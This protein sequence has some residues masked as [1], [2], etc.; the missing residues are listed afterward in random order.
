MLKN[1]I[2][3]LLGVFLIVF[4]V[5]TGCGQSSSSSLASEQIIPFDSDRWEI[6]AE[7]SK[8]EEYL[9]QQSLLL[10]GGFA[11]VE[12][13]NFTD[14]IIEYDIA[15]EKKL[16]FLG[17]V[18]RLQDKENYEH[19]YIRP[20]Q[21]GNP[22]ANQYTPEYNDIPGWQL[23]SGEGYG[24]AVEYDFEGWNHVKLIVSG[25][26]AEV[27]IRDMNEPAL[28][29]KELKREVEAGKVGFRVA[30]FA[31]A[32]LANFSYEN[33]SN[34][35]L[36]GSKEPEVTPEGTISLWSVSNSFP[37]ENLENQYLLAED[38]EEKFQWNELGIKGNG[39]ANLAEVQGIEEGNTAF[40]KVTINSDSDV[41]KKLK[42]GF[43]DRVKVYFNDRLLYGGIDDARSRDYRFLGTIGLFDELYLPLK[44]GKNELWMA[45][46][47]AVD[48]SEN[49][50]W[51]VM[52]A[53]DDLDGISISTNDQ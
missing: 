43:S 36:K 1:K 44:Q 49:N 27:Y 7:E 2:K 26:D 10:K 35:P 34:P 13:S 24:A 9:G 29:V 20:H 8:I 4:L 33:I 50:G 21:S 18:W 31:P 14:G 23:Y 30:K 22:D 5:V 37:V 40:A 32:H 28:V 47:E 19:F 51:G 25:K 15:F 3:Y 46:S 52:A 42:F 11:L 41:I 12:D 38:E 48:G 6:Q 53:F 45:V 16:G 39:V 17:V